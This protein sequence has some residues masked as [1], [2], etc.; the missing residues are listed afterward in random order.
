MVTDTIIAA[1]EHV[2]DTVDDLIR[3]GG[4]RDDHLTFLVLAGAVTLLAFTAGALPALL[5]PP[6]MAAAHR[7]RHS[8]PGVP[9][10]HLGAPDAL[11][12]QERTKPRNSCGSPTT[13]TGSH[14]GGSEHAPATAEGRTRRVRLPPRSQNAAPAA[15]GGHL[16]DESRRH[17]NAPVVPRI[18]QPD[19][20]RRL[21]TKPRPGRFKYLDA[22]RPARRAKENP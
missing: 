3:A 4:V 2:E 17:G 8:T 1:A 22:A 5:L 6:G 14:R 19:V 15:T 9:G 18:A 16:H 7:G 12:A 13:T 11:A 21:N 20:A 10:D